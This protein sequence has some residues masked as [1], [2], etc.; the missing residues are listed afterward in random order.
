MKRLLILALTLVACGGQVQ[1]TQASGPRFVVIGNQQM[2]GYTLEVICDSTQ[3][4][5]IYHS[6]SGSVAVFGDTR[7]GSV[8]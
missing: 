8:C 4:V 6:T 1:T 7:A 5:I 3:N 2:N